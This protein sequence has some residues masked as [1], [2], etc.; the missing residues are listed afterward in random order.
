MNPKII[1]IAAIA[2]IVVIFGGIMLT[3]DSTIQDENITAIDVPL[4]SADFNYFEIDTPENSNFTVKN[5]LNETSKG[6]VYWKNTGNYSKEVEGIII[7]KNLTDQ[8]IHENM[9]LLTNDSNTKVYESNGLYQIVK[10]QNDTDII[11]TGSNLHVLNEMITS[12]KIKDTKNITS[13]KP[14]E[15]TQVEKVVDKNK[16]VKKA[17]KNTTKKVETTKDT[18]KKTDNK[19]NIETTKDT[20]KTKN[21]TKKVETTKEKSKKTNNKKNI[22]TTKDTSKKTSKKVETTSE[23]SL[24]KTSGQIYVGGGIF[25]TGSGLNDKTNAKIYIDGGN[26]GESVIIKIKYYR[27]GN[28]LNKGNMVTKTIQNDGYID[29]NSADAYKYYPDKAHIE[30][31]DLDGNL[32]STQTVTL[33]PDSSTQYF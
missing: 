1:I 30:L 33:N 11:L 32:Q 22:E 20:S 19:K 17:K 3:Q 25:K 18:S 31:Y 8:L 15:E 14:V 9:N 26:P 21:T 28:S 7:D 10:T 23:K 6:M 5:A 29:I 24:K 12:A 27:D 4:K 13:P 2:L 16:E